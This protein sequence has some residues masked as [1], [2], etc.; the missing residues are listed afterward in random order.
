MSSKY[1]PKWMQWV[2]D[3]P[4]KAQEIFLFVVAALWAPALLGWL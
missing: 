1:D 3:N 4:W 2:D